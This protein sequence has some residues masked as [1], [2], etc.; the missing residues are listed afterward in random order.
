MAS[1]RASPDEVSLPALLRLAAN[2]YA[3]AVRRS[4]VAAG[5]DDVPRD[6]VFVLG[7]LSRTGAPL[8]EVIRWLG[9]SK[10]AAGQL[11][12]TLVLRGYLERS[13]DEEDRRRLR[14]NLTER[15]RAVAALARQAVEHIDE[16]LRASVAAEHIAHT[17]TT[18]LS[19][20]VLGQEWF[21]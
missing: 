7:S 21:S 1:M 14:V 10:Q 9:V 16:R 13:V 11:V 5:F 3:V 19:L 20:I 6:G 2:R 4:L 12:D 17:R 8:A 15:G 18:L